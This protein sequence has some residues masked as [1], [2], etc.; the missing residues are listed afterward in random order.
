M[1]SNVMKST[2]RE[3]WKI[4]L[5]PPRSNFWGWGVGSCMPILAGAH[6]D[7][8]LVM[9][10]LALLWLSAWQPSTGGWGRYV[11][12]II[13]YSISIMRFRVFLFDIFFIFDEPSI[14]ANLR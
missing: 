8:R 7:M 11:T 14:F 6:D 9:A 13:Y 10:K 5:K 4:F 3:G 1:L 2:G 12:S